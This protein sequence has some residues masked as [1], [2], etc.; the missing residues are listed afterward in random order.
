MSAGSSRTLWT[1]VAGGERLQVETCSART[2]LAQAERRTGQA[3]RLVDLEFEAE[4][5]PLRAEPRVR[6]TTGPTRF[7]RRRQVLKP[8]ALRRR[9]D[10]ESIAGIARALKLPRETVRDW[11]LAA[12]V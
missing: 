8:E 3:A 5:R 4:A 10:G 12:G 1:V 2:A 9:G 11:L 6:R 7:E